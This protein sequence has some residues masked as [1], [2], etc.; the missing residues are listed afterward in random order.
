MVGLGGWTPFTRPLTEKPEAEV[1][2]ALEMGARER[3]EGVTMP[4]AEMLREE[5]GVFKL[6][7]PDP[8]VAEIPELERTIDLFGK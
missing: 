1:D 7:P 8:S 4:F 2:G 5:A 6:I 3:P